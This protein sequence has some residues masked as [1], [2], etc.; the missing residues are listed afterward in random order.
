MLIVDEHSIA[1]LGIVASVVSEGALGVAWQPAGEGEW[2]GVVVGLAVDE[3][4]TIAIVVVV[5][6]GSVGGQVVSS[7]LAGS[8]LLH[9]KGIRTTEKGEDQQKDGFVHNLNK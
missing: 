1:S 4:T 3:G 7:G 2:S 5:G 9:M 6:W 8:V